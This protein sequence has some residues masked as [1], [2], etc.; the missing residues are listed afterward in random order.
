[1][2][3]ISRTGAAVRGGSGETIGIGA[4]MHEDRND[5]SDFLEKS[6]LREGLLLGRFKRGIRKARSDWGMTC[7]QI[8]AR[9]VWQGMEQGKR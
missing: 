9:Q 4:E 7:G 1:L 5:D 2:I 8:E 3:G 6:I